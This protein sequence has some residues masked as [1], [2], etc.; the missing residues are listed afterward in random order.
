MFETHRESSTDQQSMY[1]KY[2][3]LLNL[4]YQMQASNDGVS[5]QEIQEKL[6]VS[7]RTAERMV[8]AIVE[9]NSDVEI[10]QK[11]PKRWR[12]KSAIAAPNPTA[13]HLAILD[14]AAKMFKK[15][16]MKKHH[17]GAVELN[18]MLRVNM[19]HGNLTRVDADVEALSRSE[20][21]SYRP[22]PRPKLESGVVEDLQKAIKGY[23]L[24]SFDYKSASGKLKSWFEVHP[25]GFLHGNHTRSYLLAFSESSKVDDLIPFTLTKISNLKVDS[26]HM[27]ERRPELSVEHYLKDCFGVFKEKK[28][29]KVVW[30]FDADYADVVQEWT[31]HPS[32]QTTTLKDGRVEVRFKACGLHEMAWHVITWGNIIEVVK[33]KKLIE[34]LREIKRSIR[35]PEQNG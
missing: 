17:N 12:I 10:V 18:T 31:F 4:V 25:Y 5:Y 30:R 33:P 32:Q 8:K 7:R 2:L 28:R 6:K 19:T 29:Y 27:F 24:V 1:T 20:V 23:N 15:R 14:A 21:F 9:S 26:D 22:G 13:E 35:L 34:K 11:R 3:N 16:G